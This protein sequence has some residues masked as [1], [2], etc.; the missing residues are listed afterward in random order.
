MNDTWNK[1]P[2]DEVIEKTINALQ[3]NGFEVM[4]VDNK[5][6]AKQKI[7]EVIPEGSE[8]MDM[9]S[10]TLKELEILDILHSS[11]YKSVKNTLS[12]MK[13]ETHNLE[14]QKLGAAPDYAIGSIHALTQD[15]H[16]IIASQ[17][18]SQLPAY[19]YG[20]PHV[21]WVVGAQKIVKSIDEGIKRIYE[22][23][24]PLEDKRA[25]EAYGSNSNVDKIL[26]MNAEP[27][28]ERIKIIL[29]KEILGF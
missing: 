9:T 5:A 22:H 28:K 13:R 14:M 24:Y 7:L 11:K 15:G 10:M 27:K 23:S 18:G 26:I 12:Q 19:A 8:V 29:V 2:T 17:S 25:L 4:V 20:S 3:K 6:E 21:I 1:L 16:V